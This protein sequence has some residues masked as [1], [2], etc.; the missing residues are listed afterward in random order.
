VE[1]IES[2]ADVVP[3]ADALAEVIESKADAPAEVI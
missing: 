3:E 1:E 2:H